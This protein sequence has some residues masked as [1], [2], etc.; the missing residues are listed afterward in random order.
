MQQSTKRKIAKEII[1]F[2]CSVTLIGLVWAIFWSINNFN[3]SKTE[4]LQKQIVFSNHD[5]DSIQS[6][7]PKLKTFQDLITGKV[8]VEYLI[9]Q[10]WE[11]YRVPSLDELEGTEQEK[12][13][14]KN[15]SRLYSL[16]RTSKYKFSDDSVIPDFPQ[17]KDDIVEEFESDSKGQQTLN[18]IYTFLKDQKYLTVEFV[19]FTFS[20][21]ALLLPPKFITWTTYQD[22]IKKRDNLKKD[23]EVYKAKIYSTTELGD[24]LKWTS[25]FV[26]TIVY[27]FRFLMLLLFWS[28]R[29]LRQK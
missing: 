5:I 20:L 10:K 18:N 9:E 1:I 21:N 12:E 14:I 3:V 7:F 23:L 25:I 17:F 19:E 29:T 8:P 11:K 28:I 24:I 27:P 2:F 6:T 4:N 16:L 26:L 15:I 13:R 22:E